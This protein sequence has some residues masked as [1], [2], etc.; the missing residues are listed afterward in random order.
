MGLRVGVPVSTPAF[1]VN[2]M[3]GSGFQSV[4]SAVQEIV[5]MSSSIVLAGGSENMSEA[6]F[7]VRDIR[8]G[9]RLGTDMKVNSVRNQC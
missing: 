8:F 3:C 7:A 6:P 2:R 4:I 5:S 1:A 9:T